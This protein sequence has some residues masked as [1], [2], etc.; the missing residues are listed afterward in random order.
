VR[1]R[2]VGTHVLFL[3][4]V[5]PPT[6]A[7]GRPCR[8]QFLGVSSRESLATGRGFSTSITGG[9]PGV[10]P[11]RVRFRRPGSDSHPISSHALLRTAVSRDATGATEYQ[12]AT[13]CLRSPPHVQARKDVR[14]DPL[15]VSAPVR[16]WH[17][18]SPRLWLFF[19]LTPR[20]ALLSTCRRSS[21][22]ATNS[23]EAV[24]TV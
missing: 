14:R 16:S 13:A 10:C 12:S 17:S 7:G 24:R 11:F 21:R 2:T 5:K 8:P 1:C 3:P 4:Q 23:T 20:R 18:N 22:R 19:H 9:S 15:R 6:E